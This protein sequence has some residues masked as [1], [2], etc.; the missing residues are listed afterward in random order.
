ML[1]LHVICIRAALFS[2]QLLYCAS[3]LATEGSGRRAQVQ[4]LKV[5]AWRCRVRRPKACHE[6]VL[7]EA[8][9]EAG[10][11][12]GHLGDVPSFMAGL[13]SG[14]AACR[15][16]N[17]HCLV[18]QLCHVH[19]SNILRH[20]GRQGLAE[21]RSCNCRFFLIDLHSRLFM[22]SHVRSHSAAHPCMAE[23]K[24]AVHS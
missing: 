9:Q 20:A 14:V 22:S 24:P 3:E 21:F 17:V 19:L 2:G 4:S 13:F 8:S 18:L 1:L 15:C 11:P 5:L 10:S 23:V 7:V 12:R 16:T 6:V